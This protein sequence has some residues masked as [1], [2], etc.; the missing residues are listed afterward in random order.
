MLDQLQEA[1]ENL[2]ASINEKPRKSNMYD[3]QHI[4][5]ILILM[6]RATGPERDKMNEILRSENPIFTRKDKIFFHDAYDHC[7]D[8]IE[9]INSLEQGDQPDHRVY[10]VQIQ[11][12]FFQLGTFRDIHLRT[13]ASGLDPDDGESEA[14]A[15]ARLGLKELR[16]AFNPSR[17]SV[18]DTEIGLYGTQTQGE[19]AQSRGRYGTDAEQERAAEKAPEGANGP[20]VSPDIAR[21]LAR[22]RGAEQ[23]LSRGR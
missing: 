21:E 6:H 1:L 17:E 15:M 19:I 8:I 18:A 20:Q 5:R 11:T 2:E 22:M 10:L 23:S 9:T 4:K 13:V 16:N 12:C 3:V 7:I 14:A